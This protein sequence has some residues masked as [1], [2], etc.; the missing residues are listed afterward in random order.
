MQQELRNTYAFKESV[1]YRLKAAATLLGENTNTLRAYAN[2]FEE[3]TG[4]RIKRASDDNSSSPSV[5]VFTPDILF[6][7]ASWKRKK[8][9]TKYRLRKNSLTVVFSII[10][11]GSGKTTTCVEAAINTQL[12][13]YRCLLIDF[14]STSNTTHMMG[15]EPDLVINEAS[16]YG[17]TS[18]AIIQHT[19]L[20]V[21]KPFIESGRNTQPI[22]APPDLIKKPFGEDGPHLIPAEAYLSD[23]ETSLSNS[24]GM[25]ELYLRNFLVAA[26][27]GQIE[28]L[29]L[30][31]YDFIMMDTFP[32][33]TMMVQNALAAADV[34]VCPVK[35]DDFAVKGVAKLIGELD[36]IRH[37][38]KLQQELIVLPTHYKKRVSR[39]G[40]ME[41]ELQKFSPCMIDAVISFSEDFSN[42]LGDY[43]PL[44]IVDPT[45]SAAAEYRHFTLQ[46]IE[47]MR[48]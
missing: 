17:L 2:T 12:L 8:N 35:M 45:S 19:M 5:R 4:L 42:S 41:K 28:G 15:Y 20:D 21:L 33:A 31:Q 18:E 9:P 22:Q 13:G 27:A 44:S 38:Y 39:L 30:A 24:K 32:V 3:E 7:I 36:T 46:F 14:D 43:L 37:T 10:K 34:V 6:Q 23:L 11:G 47:R 40:R 16:E 26:Q 1:E 29:D 25:R 48:G